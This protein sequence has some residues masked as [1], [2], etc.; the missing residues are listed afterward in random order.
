MWASQVMRG[1][2]RWPVLRD[3]TVIDG[4]PHPGLASVHLAGRL[5][6]GVLAMV[7]LP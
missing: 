5:S 1:D 7:H 2:V 4:Q 3:G 6:G